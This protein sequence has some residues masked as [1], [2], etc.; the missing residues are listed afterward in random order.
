[1]MNLNKLTQIATILLLN[2]RMPSKFKI[3]Q[4][5]YCD[6]SLK[7]LSTSLNSQNH[8]AFL[9]LQP[10]QLQFIS[11][12]MLL[13]VHCVILKGSGVILSSNCSSKTEGMLEQIGQRAPYFKVK[14][15]VQFYHK[16]AI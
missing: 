8:I 4:L 1:M 5:A 14:E 13:A 16:F 6:H 3:H 10:D 15:D 2:Y 9:V 12:S 11:T 7:H